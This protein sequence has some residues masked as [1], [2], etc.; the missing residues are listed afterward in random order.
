MLL[1]CTEEYSTY[2]DFSGL[3]CEVDFLR[4]SFDTWV[5]WNSLTTSSSSCKFQSS[6]SQPL[7]SQGTFLFPFVDPEREFVSVEALVD[8]LFSQEPLLPLDVFFLH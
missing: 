2:S 7:D 4:S 8:D 1:E 5:I 3:P 6:S